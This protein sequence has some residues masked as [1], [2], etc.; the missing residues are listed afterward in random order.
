MGNEIFMVHDTVV[1][2]VDFEMANSS[3]LTLQCR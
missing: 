2:R 3:G 1:K